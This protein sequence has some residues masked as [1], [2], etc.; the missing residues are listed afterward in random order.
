MPKVFSK[1]SIVVIGR[2]TPRNKTAMKTV[3]QMSRTLLRARARLN[4][5]IQGLQTVLLETIN[6]NMPYLA[7]S[8]IYYFFNCYHK[9]EIM[10]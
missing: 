1:I 10:I 6:L 9:S 4:D 8:Y 7:I 2:K 5:S 3:V